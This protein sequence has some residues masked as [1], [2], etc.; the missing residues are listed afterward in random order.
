MSD[1]RSDEP[2]S[3]VLTGG[4]ARGA[5]EF[6]ALSVLLPELERLGQRPRI[7]LGTSV[8][9]LNVAYLAAT[10]HLPADE[11][12]RGGEAIW[13]SLGWADVIRHVISLASAGRA[14]SYLGQAGG[15]PGARLRSLLDPTP[16]GATIDRTIDFTRLGENVERGAL[17]AAAVVTTS[18]LTHRTVVFHHGGGSP[19]FDTRRL[20]NYV[21]TPVKAEHVRASTSMPAVFPAALVDEPPAAA[22]WYYDGG[23]RLNAPLKPALAF[24]AKRIVV[25]GL[26]SLAPGRGAIAGDAQPDA[27]GGLSLL[28]QDLI[29]DQFV[30]DVHTLARVNED[31]RAGS[32]G[33]RMPVPYIVVAPQ[34]PDTIEELALGIFRK[35]YHGLGGLRRSPDIDILGKLI[36]A[37][38]E[39]ANATLLSLLLFDPEFIESLIDL[40]AS[41]ARRWIGKRHDGPEPLWQ[42]GRI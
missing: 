26:S 27:F 5:Y 3:L 16:L 8:G 14:V 10:A 21:A 7:L 39:A 4:C 11:S 9:A 34:Q 24:G 35:H 30:Q 38:A 37:G 2:V 42:L 31:I 13:R 25:I 23:T 20:I 32:R 33:G 19:G 17:T 28:L 15:W 36:G 6:G 18:A 41:D 1:A 29:G 22:G 40:G 12:V